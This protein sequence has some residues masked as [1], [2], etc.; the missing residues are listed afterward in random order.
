MSKKDRFNSIQRRRDARPTR[1]TKPTILIV[2]EGE[3]TEPY[4]FNSF[5]ITS[6]NVVTQGGKGNTTGLV[7][8]A[9]KMAKYYDNV[10]CVFDKDDFP[11][12]NYN[13]ACQKAQLHQKLN[14]ACSNESFELWY[15]L[16][17]H[18][19]CVPLERKQITEKLNEVM[20]KEL[21][22]SYEKNLQNMYELLL[23]RQAI[24][25]ANSNRLYEFHSENVANPTHSQL[26]PITFV[27]KLVEYL[28][29]VMES[30]K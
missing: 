18:F 24:A 9:E 26:N 8:Y 21:N 30:W 3:K 12:N 4:Y 15:L 20:I 22:Q 11:D 29:S 10:W 13:T 14:L 2:C 28:N 7:D 5:R 17:F 1:E 25:I 23:D 19:V 16:H 27:H 6:L